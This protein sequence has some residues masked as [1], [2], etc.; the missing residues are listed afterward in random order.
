MLDPQYLLGDEEMQQFIA[1]GYLTLKSLVARFP[2]IKTSTSAPRMSLPRRGNPRQQRPA[3]HPGV[4]AG[5]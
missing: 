2:S 4:A 5:L 1:E 3:S